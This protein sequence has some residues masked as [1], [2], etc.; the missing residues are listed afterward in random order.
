M[1]DE[2]LQA[3]YLPKHDPD[4]SGNVLLDC[5]RMPVLGSRFAE[6]FVREPWESDVRKELSL[7]RRIDCVIGINRYLKPLS[8]HM[9]LY[10]GI[11]AVI[12]NGYLYK[13][14]T[15]KPGPADV[16]QRYLQSMQGN[17]TPI[18]EAEP[19]AP[20]MGLFGCS[21]MGKSTVIERCLQFIP[22]A[23]HHAELGITQIVW[24][25]ID[26][27]RNGRLKG[28]LLSILREVDRT[29]GT[30]YRVEVGSRPEE[31]KLLEK[32]T[33]VMQRHY[34]GLLVL[35]E[36]QYLRYSA[37]GRDAVLDFFVS[38]S[39][40]IRC[41]YICVGTLLGKEMLQGT[42]R[43]ARRISD[44]G[45]HVWTPMRM[46]GDWDP[47][48]KSLW[49]YQ[50]VK[51]PVELSTRISQ[52]LYFRT[53]GIPALAV[54]LFQLAQ[55][56]AIE[57]GLSDVGEDL[58]NEMADKHFVLLEPIL[59]QLARASDGYVSTDEHDA[60]L[61]EQLKNIGETVRKSKKTHRAARVG[62]PTSG[63]SGVG[64]PMPVGKT[65][66][67]PQAVVPDIPLEEQIKSLTGPQTL[68]DR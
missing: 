3:Y 30:G 42:L 43:E 41:P 50:W 6:K 34:V 67:Q 37:Q 57:Y 47:F 22:K 60:L 36:V 20:A 15:G 28:L 55:L 40:E 32:V 9:E 54:R 65:E 48:V 66:V 17:F 45:V 56:T 25:K 38:C 1:S 51:C 8:S 23:L 16:R 62:R 35:D 26:C 7:E 2:I 63:F 39:N 21:G 44:A 5:F 53:Q 58:I 49:K 64:M 27:P 19:H 61:A 11:R 10:S 52:T 13:D 68:I 4:Y 59:K 24:L 12:R 18:S 33:E 46:G 31:V 14:P 29:I